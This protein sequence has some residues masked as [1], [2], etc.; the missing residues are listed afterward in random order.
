VLWPEDLQDH[1]HRFTI[2][3]CYMIDE[4]EHKGQRQFGSVSP[5]TR[6]CRKCM[7]WLHPDKACNAQP[8]VKLMSSRI[9]FVPKKETGHIQTI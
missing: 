9:N 5:A 7:E 6:E 1:K 3:Y 2:P 4:I 8:G